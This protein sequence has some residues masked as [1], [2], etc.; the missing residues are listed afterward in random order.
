MFLAIFRAPAPGD[1]SIAGWE[2]AKKR[3]KRFLVIPGEQKAA[4]KKPLFLPPFHPC[5]PLK[6]Q[7]RGFSPIEAIFRYPLPI[8]RDRNSWLDQPRIISA[9]R[10]R[11]FIYINVLL[12]PI[13]YYN[14]FS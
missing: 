1:L 3:K 10:I 13:K 14:L 5:P 11:I 8:L 4:L 7:I 2:Q 9:L 6:S 12:L